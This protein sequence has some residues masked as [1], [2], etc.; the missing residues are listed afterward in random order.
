MPNEYKLNSHEN[1]YNSASNVNSI[2]PTFPPV[3]PFVLPTGSTGAT[4]LTGTT[5]PTGTTG[6]TGT[7]GP[8]GPLSPSYG[9]FW[10]S[11]GALVNVGDYIPF[12]FT[13]PSTGGVTLSNLTT[14]NIAQAGDYRV[15]F[16]IQIETFR[17]PISVSPIVSIFSNNN[18]LPNKQGTFAIT[19]E[20]KNLL[21]RFQLTGEAVISVPSNSTIQLFNL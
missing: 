10:N 5:G 6:L 11:Y 3:E 4:G 14:I 20:D 2:G 18:H 13:G 19:V 12:Y 1:L 7:T 17:S 21:P 16:I 9:N 8:T 15:S